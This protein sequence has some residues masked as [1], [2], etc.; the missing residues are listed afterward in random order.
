MQ[1][2]VC[3]RVVSC[4]RL[5]A[6]PRTVACQALLSKEFSKPENWSGL[7]FPPSGDLSDW[8]I[9]L[10]SLASPALAGGFL[11]TEPPGF[12]EDKMK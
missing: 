11:T 8:R 1:S 2:G 5:F 9:E 3:V 7:P 12:W 4:V 10:A 6:N